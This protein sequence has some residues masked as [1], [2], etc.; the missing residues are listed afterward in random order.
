MSSCSIKKLREKESSD[1]TGLLAFPG[2]SKNGSTLPL[3]Q[4]EINPVSKH[5]AKTEIVPRKW[6]IKIALR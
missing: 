2:Q 1:Y 6:K 3:H 4:T 5:V